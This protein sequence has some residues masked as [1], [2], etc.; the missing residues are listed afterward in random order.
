MEG[1]HFKEMIDWCENNP[2][3]AP[4]RLAGLIPVAIGDKF[5][6]EAIALIDKYADKQYVLNE[7]ACT[8]DSFLLQALL[9]LITN[10]VKIY[11][12]LLNHKNDS[13]RQWAQQNVNSCKYMIQKEME[14]E[15]EI[16]D[17]Y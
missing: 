15:K 2:D 14:R 11:S 4:A 8:L 10:D 9:F 12:S 6:P 13:V 5:T 7:I 17:L 3:I 16:F 1:N